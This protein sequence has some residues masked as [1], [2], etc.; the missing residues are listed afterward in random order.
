MGKRAHTHRGGAHE[1]WPAEPRLQKEGERG[2]EGERDSAACRRQKEDDKVGTGGRRDHGHR[3]FHTAA[4][5]N[6]P[7]PHCRASSAETPASHFCLNGSTGRVPD[8]PFLLLPSS[9]AFNR[10]F[11][12]PFIG[13]IASASISRSISSH[14][15]LSAQFNRPP[16]ATHHH[17]SSPFLPPDACPCLSSFNPSSPCPSPPPPAPLSTFYTLSLFNPSPRCIHRSSPTPPPTGIAGRSVFRSQLALSAGHIVFCKVNGN[18]LARFSSVF[19][20]FVRFWLF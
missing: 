8:P 3:V 14:L 10:L 15:L 11:F 5:V 1:S 12:H 20:F 17:A 16:T 4:L 6:I 7:L 2:R 13:P 19:F 9:P 18:C